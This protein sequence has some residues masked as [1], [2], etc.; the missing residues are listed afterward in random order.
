MGGGGAGRL[1]MR[2]VGGGKRDEQKLRSIAAVFRFSSAFA[3]GEGGYL[4]SGL[5]QTAAEVVLVKLRWVALDV[6]AGA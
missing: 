5:L 2:S 1:G 3:C 6:E 4:E